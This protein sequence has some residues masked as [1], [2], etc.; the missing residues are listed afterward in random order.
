MPTDP[1]RPSPGTAMGPTGDPSPDLPALTAEDPR[2]PLI[3]LTTLAWRGVPGCDAVSVTVRVGE[4]FETTAASDDVAREMVRVQYDRGAGPCVR[5]LLHGEVVDVEDCRT[6]ARWPQCRK[7]GLARGV[8]SSLSLPLRD[9]TR[10]LGALDL[11]ADERCA[12]GVPSHEVADECARVTAVV[13][14]P[15]RHRIDL[16]DGGVGAREDLDRLARATQRPR[17]WFRSSEV[18]KV[19]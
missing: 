2:E 5:S 7:A 13:P 1:G 11:Y 16:G 4:G 12:S 6:E 8:G 19:P 18:T 15:V 14:A 3:D 17:R 9:G 10:I